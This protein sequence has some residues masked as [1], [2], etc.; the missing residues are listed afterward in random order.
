MSKM[1][2]AS[3]TIWELSDDE[4]R[5]FVRANNPNVGYVRNMLNKRIAAM[6]DE[7]ERIEWRLSD[8]TQRG[9]TILILGSI[10]LA[11]V[12]VE[13]N[14]I[15]HFLSWVFPFLVVGI[16]SFIF[17]TSRKFGRISNMPIAAEGME[18]ELVFLR[19][20]ARGIAELW[21]GTNAC[22]NKVL[23]WYNI[24]AISFFLY[25]VLFL[26]NFYCYI[27][28][29][30]LGVFEEV[31]IILFLLSLGGCIYSKRYSKEKFKN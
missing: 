11:L 6:K 3:K 12:A 9:A 2:S 27:F 19:K 18:E 8:M 5:G 30:P 4:L 26:V 15:E 14:N 25:F 13:Q 17:S 24:T 10:S 7:M 28:L 31:L 16:F 21:E 23:I 20:E 22:Y 1:R 29:K